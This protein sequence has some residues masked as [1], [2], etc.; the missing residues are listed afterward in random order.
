M[1]AGYAGWRAYG[2][3][4]RDLPL[5]LV[6]LAGLAGAGLVLHVTVMLRRRQACPI[7]QLAT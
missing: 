1:P 4:I 5:I 3:A 7:P 6:D 2:I